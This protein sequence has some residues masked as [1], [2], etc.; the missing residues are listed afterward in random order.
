M[1]ASPFPIAISIA[2][3]IASHM[4]DSYRS[5]EG[6]FKALTCLWVHNIW[7][8]HV[9]APKPHLTFSGYDESLM[10]TSI[11][12]HIFGPQINKVV[13]GVGQRLSRGVCQCV[14]LCT[15]VCVFERAF[16]QSHPPSGGKMPVLIGGRAKA[17]SPMRRS[18]AGRIAD[19]FPSFF[20]AI[21]ACQAVGVPSIIDHIQGWKAETLSGDWA[22]LAPRRKKKKKRGKE[23]QPGLPTLCERRRGNIFFKSYWTV[24]ENQTVWKVN[25]VLH[26]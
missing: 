2:G 21:P 17:P 15:R 8:S 11:G 7:R 14:S 10:M 25:T 23:T 12:F 9:Y 26:Q 22:S 5:V 16:K 20:Q 18:G 24:T 1:I 6:F 19:G 3:I 13:R 4:Y